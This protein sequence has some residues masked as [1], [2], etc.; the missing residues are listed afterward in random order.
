[1]VFDIIY[2]NSFAMK[3]NHFLYECSLLPIYRHNQPSCGG[4][5]GVSS[6][7]AAAS[8]PAITPHLL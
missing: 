1:M 4:C 3:I 2:H 5:G 6:E 7:S 8:P